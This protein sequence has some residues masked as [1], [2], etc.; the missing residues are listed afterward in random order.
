MVSSMGTFILM[1]ACYLMMI[2]PLYIYFMQAETVISEN[3]FFLFRWL[4]DN[5]YGTYF[6]IDESPYQLFFR[7]ITVVN[8]IIANVFLL[9]YLIAILSTIYAEREEQGDFAYKQNKYQ[10]I[11][12]Y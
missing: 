6:F 10:Y 8:V 9:N 3:Q 2:S 5:V 11:E 12:R 1:I 4:V 7:I